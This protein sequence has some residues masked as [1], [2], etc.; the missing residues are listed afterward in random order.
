M[1]EL[2]EKIAYLR[3]LA[4]GIE[5]DEDRK[6]G[7][8]LGSL[9]EVVDQLTEH[10]EDLSFDVSD[11]EEYVTYIDEDLTEVEDT[12]F[13]VYDDFDEFEDFDELAEFEYEDCDD[14][15]VHECGHGCHGHI[16]EDEEF[17]D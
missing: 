10:V 2:Y 1:E 16:S 9:L 13:D 12:V 6:I 7:K 15:Y 4:D 17:E 11:L 8:L 14:N 5:L 3:G